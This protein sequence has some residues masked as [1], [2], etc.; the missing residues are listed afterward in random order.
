MVASF[1]KKLSRIALQVPPHSILFILPLIYNL[2]HDHPELKI[3][4]HRYDEYKD[5]DE[6]APLLIG[7]N[8]L[9]IFEGIDPFLY[10]EKDLKRTNALESTLWEL[11]SLRKHYN[12]MVSKMANSLKEKLKNSEPGFKI[13]DFIDISYDQLFIEEIQIEKNYNLSSEPFQLNK[14]IFIQ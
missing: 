8:K 3:L 13:N 4:V 14:K 10:E 6:N 12:P 2:M 11:E 9:K 5:I 7:Q 1:I